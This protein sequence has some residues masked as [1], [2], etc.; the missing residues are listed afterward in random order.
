[1]SNNVRISVGNL[2]SSQHYRTPN[3]RLKWVLA[4]LS[5]VITNI[6][7]YKEICRSNLP[8]EDVVWDHSLKSDVPGFTLTQLNS[9]YQREMTGVQNVGLYTHI[10]IVVE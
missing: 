7:I 3:S 5:R 2:F 8:I 10:Q 4:F 9:I 6:Y 1:M